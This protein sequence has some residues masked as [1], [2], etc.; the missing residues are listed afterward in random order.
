MGPSAPSSSTKGGNEISRSGEK[1]CV[2]LCLATL[3]H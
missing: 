1:L 2:T 3:W